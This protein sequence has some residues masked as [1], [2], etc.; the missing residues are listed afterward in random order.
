MGS[1]E[2]M[3]L[4]PECDSLFVQVNHVVHVEDL[5]P[6]LCL[7]A[8][9]G[10][11][12]SRASVWRQPG[13]L[14]RF[15]RIK[16]PQSPEES[17]AAVPAEAEVVAYDTALS[18]SRA[19]LEAKEEQSRE[20]HFYSLF[21]VVYVVD[22]EE[23][24]RRSNWGD[25]TPGGSERT[26][27]AEEGDQDAYF[28]QPHLFSPTPGDTGRDRPDNRRRW[29]SVVVARA[30][31]RGEKF[32]HGLGS[33]WGKEAEEWDEEARGLVQSVLGAAPQ[34]WLLFNDFRVEAIDF[35]DAIDCTA[36]WKRPAILLFE[37]H[38]VLR[39]QA[40]Q[41][42]DLSAA[43]ELMFPSVPLEV[44][45]LPKG[46]KTVPL[47]APVLD[48]KGLP[49]SLRTFYD[50][51]PKEGEVVAIDAEFVAVGLEEA[52]YQSDGTRRVLEQA[53]MFPGRVR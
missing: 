28:M 46:L 35:E 7:T 38:P 20:Y 29:H 26:A 12:S 10:N 41:P 16:L 42:K 45:T 37:R 31:R 48:M 6:F 22:T 19:V 17:G 11:S 32:Q 14:S 8:G 3:F 44:F 50:S 52:E 25:V 43:G 53:R 24:T 4:V 27:Q 21:G 40:P 13:F 2:A 47:K 9:I 5:P 36:P 15:L 33:V 51:L 18:F 30:E 49:Q 1:T 39:V 34:D 23:V